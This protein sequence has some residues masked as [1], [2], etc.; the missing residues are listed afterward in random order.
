MNDHIEYCKRPLDT[1]DDMDK[2]VALFRSIEF[3]GIK[4]VHFCV[5]VKQAGQFVQLDDYAA[6][7]GGPFVPTLDDF[8]QAFINK[9]QDGNRLLLI[10]QQ[11]RNSTTAFDTSEWSEND[12]DHTDICWRFRKIMRKI[13]RDQELLFKENKT[14][15]SDRPAQTTCTPNTKNKPTN[16]HKDIVSMLKTIS[17]QLSALSQSVNQLAN[18]LEEPVEQKTSCP[19]N[20]TNKII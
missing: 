2:G 12:E 1:L 15:L 10:D 3:T 5:A 6:H 14:N 11:L 4:Y 19:C 9:Y 13:E 20:V 7:R 17:Q 8:V 16:D 18:Q